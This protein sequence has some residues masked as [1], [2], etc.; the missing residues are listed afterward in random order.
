[1]TAQFQYDCK[2]DAQVRW[3]GWPL[4]AVLAAGLS[5]LA[6]GLGLFALL[7]GNSQVILTESLQQ[8]VV[9]LESQLTLLNLE[10]FDTLA[11]R[12]RD[13]SSC[14]CPPGKLAG[15]LCMLLLFVC[16]VD[17]SH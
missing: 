7:T 4:L 5:L 3:S 17:F 6:C 9:Q 10:Q 12:K 13:T 15:S 11:R 1:M 8:R 2:P 14:T 16:A